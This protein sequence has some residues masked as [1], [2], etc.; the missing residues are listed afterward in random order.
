MMGEKQAKPGIALTRLMGFCFSQ[1]HHQAARSRWSST[2]SSQSWTGT[3]CWD[4]K[5]SSSLTWSQRKTPATLTVSA[6]GIAGCI[7]T[8]LVDCAKWCVW[9]SSGEKCTFYAQ[10][11]AHLFNL[12][13]S[14]ASALRS[15]SPHQYVRRGRHQWRRACRDQTVLFL[16][17]SLQQ[18]LT[19][20]PLS[21]HLPS[22][23]HSARC[24][25][26][27]FLSASTCFVFF[28]LWDLCLCLTG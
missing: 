3:L 18:G 22:P 8:G 9:R 13:A 11:A 4:K 19:A 2:P 23:C 25:S 17:P 27:I 24:F 6:F 10:P 1:L 28:S 14:P 21:F 26:L 15:L 20:L 12:P 16:F 5:P 7:D